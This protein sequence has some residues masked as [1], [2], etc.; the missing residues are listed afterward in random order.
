MRILSLAFL[1]ISLGGKAQNALRYVGDFT[2]KSAAEKVS[3]SLKS[4]ILILDQRVFVIPGKCLD[5]NFGGDQANNDRNFG[6][7]QANNTRNFGGDQANSNR[8]F[9]GDQAN[10][11]RNFGGDQANSNRNFGGDQANSNRN[12]G[13]DQAN[14]D[15]NFGGDNTNLKFKCDRKKGILVIYLDPQ[16]VSYAKARNRS[17]FFR[18]I[19]DNQIR[20]E[21]Y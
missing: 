4:P 14:N 19:Y 13:G 11:N 8:N 2:N 9:G 18:G 20:I 1:L 12:F 5:R 6:G 16:Q 15:R 17:V 10:S 7:D 3:D 21:K